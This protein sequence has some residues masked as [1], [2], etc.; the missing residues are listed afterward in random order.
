MTWKTVLIS[1]NSGTKT[2]NKGEKKDPEF[3]KRRLREF[4]GTKLP[5]GPGAR[6]QGESKPD[7]KGL[8]DRNSPTCILS[9]NGYVARC[10]LKFGSPKKAP[11]G[12]WERGEKTKI[13]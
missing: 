11:R 4:G 9:Q 3:N 10:I 8:R 13:P 2:K 6:I 1:K 12:V 7:Q 5:R